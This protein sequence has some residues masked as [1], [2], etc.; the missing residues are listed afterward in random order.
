MH[1]SILNNNNNKL[2]V[3]CVNCFGAIYAADYRA[4]IDYSFKLCVFYGFN[5]V[6]FYLFSSVPGP[7]NATPHLRNIFSI[8]RRLFKRSGR[9]THFIQP[10]TKSPHLVF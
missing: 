10:L 1:N 8:Q 2:E 3:N 5:F 4:R 9:L 7:S 6:S